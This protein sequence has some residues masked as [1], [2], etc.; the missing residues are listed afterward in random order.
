LTRDSAISLPE[1]DVRSPPPFLTVTVTSQSGVT[2]PH[3]LLIGSRD[4]VGCRDR[5]GFHNP[6][7]KGAANSAP[8]LDST[9]GQLQARDGRLHRLPAWQFWI[10]RCSEYL[11]T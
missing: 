7:E 4:T 5:A 8:D 1:A 3:K 10:Q 2:N 6:E 11:R 9:P